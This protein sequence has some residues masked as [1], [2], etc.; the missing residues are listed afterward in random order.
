MLLIGFVGLVLTGLGIVLHAQKHGIRFIYTEKFNL[1]EWLEQDR[2][3]RHAHNLKAEKIFYANELRIMKAEATAKKYK[4]RRATDS[5]ILAVIK[6]ALFHSKAKTERVRPHTA[7]KLTAG[8]RNADGKSGLLDFGLATCGLAFIVMVFLMPTIATPN[9]KK[10]EVIKV[11]E[12]V[13]PTN[14]AKLQKEL[15]QQSQAVLKK[16]DAKRKAKATAR[17]NATE[18]TIELY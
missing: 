4:I 14:T 13:K 15:L 3:D 9:Y 5:V 17:A 18:Q 1:A 6:N 10:Q 16:A 11:I 7:R 8:R 2:A 12:Y